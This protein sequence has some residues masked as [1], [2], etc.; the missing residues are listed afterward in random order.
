MAKRDTFGLSIMDRRTIEHDTGKL[1]Q[2]SEMVQAI[3]QNWFMALYNT[4]D[5]YLI[6]IPRK[7]VL[8]WPATFRV[9]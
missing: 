5:I 9:L 2:H 6:L 3:A 1:N 7:T 4:D 8:L